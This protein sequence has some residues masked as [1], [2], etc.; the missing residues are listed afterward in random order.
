M[1]IVGLFQ[2]LI[3]VMLCSLFIEVHREARTQPSASCTSQYNSTMHEDE[4]F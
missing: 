3:S 1:E 2:I 4:M